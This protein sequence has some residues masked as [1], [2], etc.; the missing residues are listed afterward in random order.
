MV[1]LGE[2]PAGIAAFLRPLHDELRLAAKALENHDLNV[3]PC[4]LD[5]FTSPIQERIRAEHIRIPG[6]LRPYRNGIHQ[7]ID[8][9][10]VRRGTAI[11]PVRE[12]II[13]RVDQAYQPLDSSFRSELLRLTRERW[14]GTPGSVDLPPA[15]PPYGDV[16]GRLMGRQIWIYHGTNH[17]GESVITRY[18]HLSSVDQSL[19]P[20]DRV[21]PRTVIGGVGHSGTSS[22]G[23]DSP[24]GTHL[25]LEIYVG[26]DFWHPQSKDEIG[27]PLTAERKQALRE[28]TLR[29]LP[30]RSLP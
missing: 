29:L 21:S 4:S 2:A 5:G 12:G 6:V 17:E 20:L 25:H 18:G 24:Q 3:S 16:L 7:G 1:F 9:Y 8:F 27:R 10:G 26:S 15:P 22:E 23:T 14:N 30:Q 13:L 28:K 19:R 11:F